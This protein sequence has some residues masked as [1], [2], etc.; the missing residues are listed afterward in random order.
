VHARDRAEV[1]IAQLDADRTAGVSLA[2]QIIADTFAKLG[3]DCRQ[4]LAIARRRQVTIERRLATDRLRL[5]V[6][7]D[8]P[9]VAAV[10]GVVHPLAMDAT[11][12]LDEKRMLGIREI[13]DRSNGERRK[14]RGRLRADAIDRARRKRPD[15]PL[16]IAV[17]DDG[18][19]IGLV[20]VGCDLGEQLVAR[21]ADRAR[22]AGRCANG[23]LDRLRERA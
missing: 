11:E 20:E 14:L 21:D 9:L 2:L 10:C 6:R 1:A 12:R 13:A 7:D 5:A 8:G 23:V 3:E 16:E 18:Q 4:L 15:A 22:Q 17:T 19:A